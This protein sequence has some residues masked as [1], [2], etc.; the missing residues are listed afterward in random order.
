M[1]IE[2]RSHSSRSPE[3]ALLGF[4]CDHPD[5]GYNLH[6]RLVMDLGHI[7]HI[8][9]SQTYNILKRLMEHKEISATPQKQVKLPTRQVLRVTPAGRRRFDAWLNNPTGSSV[10]DIRLEFITRLYFARMFC[11]A[12]IASMLAGQEREI[13]AVLMR[14]ENDQKEIPAEQTFNRLGLE[15]RIR[16]LRSTLDWLADCRASLV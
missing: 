7:W 15:F 5:H 13:T 8:R 10:R 12:N 16:Q 1:A 4:L 3:Y 14:L 2:K 9:Q 6:Q 11:P